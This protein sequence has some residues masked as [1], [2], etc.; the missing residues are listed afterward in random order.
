MSCILGVF[1][2]LTSGN[3]HYFW[4]PVSNGHVSL[5]CLHGFFPRRVV[6]P[7]RCTDQSSPKSSRGPSANLQCISLFRSLL[8]GSLSFDSPCL[9]VPQ[10]SSISLICRW[11]E[12][13]LGLP[14]LCHVFSQEMWQSVTGLTSLCVRCIKDHC[15]SLHEDQCLENCCFL[16]GSLSVF[17]CCCYWFRGEGNLVPAIS[18]WEEVEVPLNKHQLIKSA[19]LILTW[20]S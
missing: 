14:S 16:H 5:I 12:P 15:H 17:F 11:P 8:L 13:C 19:E 4:T 9:A 20:L 18:S 6:S 7:Y 3:R 10:P 2:S 1:P